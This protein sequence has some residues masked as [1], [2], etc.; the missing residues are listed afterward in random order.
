M[1]EI[2]LYEQLQPPPP[3]DAGRLRE[4]ARARLTTATS[5][6]LA[7]P[8]KRRSTVLAV[9]AAAALAAA[10]T[11]Y[12]LA[13][14]YGAASP[15]LSTTGGRT[16]PIGL[17][18]VQGCPGQYITAGT[19]KQ[20]SG[21]Q[22]I[23]QPASD[24]DHVN[25]AWRSQQVTVATKAS[26]VTRIPA[27]GTVSDI[28]DG[29]RVSVQGTWSGDRLAATQVDI[30]AGLPPMRSFGPRFP[31][32]PGNLRKLSPPPGTPKFGPPFATGTVKDA[33]GGDFTVLWQS[34]LQGVRRIRVTTSGST[35]VETN[36]S[37]SL[38]QLTLGA[39]IVAVGSLGHDGVMTASAVTEEPSG[40]LILLPHSPVKIRSSGCSAPAITTAVILTSG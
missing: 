7:H 38:S 1:D 32:N 15:R 21:T 40:T 25:R 20:V 4:A 29:A 18:A 8:P 23:V 37:A 16:T 22:L 26:T 27:S 31:R 17:T 30:Q 12:G 19:L 2:K 33:H 36:A 28:T 9:T 5:A 39:N 34:P 11:S 14:T 35:S 3:P 6:P 10:G 24:S 13:A